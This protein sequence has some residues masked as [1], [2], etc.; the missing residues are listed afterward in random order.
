MKVC[1]CVE[2]QPEQKKN[3]TLFAI[4]NRPMIVP[5]RVGSVRDRRVWAGTR[6]LPTEGEL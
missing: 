2:S 5:E 1:G 3:K 4:N 6:Q